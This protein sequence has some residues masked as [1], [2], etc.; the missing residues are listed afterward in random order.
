MAMAA[1]FSELRGL[2]LFEQ[3]S[4]E[5]IDR[6]DEYTLPIVGLVTLVTVMVG[7]A[8]MMLLPL[9]AKYH[10]GVPMAPVYG[11][12]FGF[13][14][15]P[16]FLLIANIVY[17]FFYWGFYSAIIYGVGNWLFR[18]QGYFLS[19]FRVFG[20][21]ML[22]T[23]FILVGLIP[24]VGSFLGLACQVW[25]ITMVLMGIKSA[26][27]IRFPKA[28]AIGAVSFLIP[29]LI[30]YL[31]M[32]SI[33]GFDFA[34]LMVTSW[35]ES[36]K[37][38]FLSMFSQPAGLSGLEGFSGDFTIPGAEENLLGNEYFDPSFDD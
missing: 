8:S 10:M 14:V 21:A 37:Y 13:A 1:L 12:M 15:F 35:I 32:A 19:I 28:I 17:T 18:E 22:T 30:W 7:F 25:F 31:V 16:A 24:Y 3:T 20:V 27:D 9:M 38:Q 23:A 11:M 6:E 26:F 2:F 36:F 29:L 34:N 5:E 4:Y 33:F